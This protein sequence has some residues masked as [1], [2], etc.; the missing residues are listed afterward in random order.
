MSSHK[1]IKSV[2]LVCNFCILP[3]SLLISLVIF[4]PT[5]NWFNSLTLFL[6]LYIPEYIKPDLL[7]F[8]LNDEFITVETLTCLSINTSLK[9]SL[10]LLDSTPSP[11][12]KALYHFKVV[13]VD[14]VETAIS[15]DSSVS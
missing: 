13:V 2:S 4:S 9:S 14:G 6:E 7:V 5:L 8:C 10:I 3:Y 11:K 12:S 15:N 1:T